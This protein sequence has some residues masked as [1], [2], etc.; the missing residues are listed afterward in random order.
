MRS[1]VTEESQARKQAL[2][3][4][5]TTPRT[6]ASCGL[7]PGPYA[8]ESGRGTRRRLRTTA[9]S[10]REWRKA[11]LEQE[12]QPDSAKFSPRSARNVRAEIAIYAQDQRS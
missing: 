6:R 9:Q 2:T 12:V 10:L 5:P 7:V 1:N 4:F 8:S 11:C 3:A